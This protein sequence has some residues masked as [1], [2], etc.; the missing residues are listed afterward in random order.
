MRLDKKLEATR[1]DALQRLVSNTSQAVQALFGE[2]KGVAIAE[3]TIN[4]FL[5]MTKARSMYAPPIGGILA[6]AELASGIATIANI[7]KTEIGSSTLSGGGR[8]SAPSS[9]LRTFGTGS[10]L[11]DSRTL[12]RGDSLDT[13]R[14]P[15]D[16]ASNQMK[17]PIVN[18]YNTANVDSKGLYITTQHG[19]KE[20]ER[21][22]TQ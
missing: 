11:P 7:A 1:L 15:I 12:T 6:A 5:A 22:T 3:A 13:G 8:D 10:S 9:A 19:R 2:S 20:Y 4:T 17:A 14:A 21:S 16:I 18:V